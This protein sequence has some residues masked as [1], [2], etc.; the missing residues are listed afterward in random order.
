MFFTINEE[1]GEIGL[2]SSF[3]ERDVDGEGQDA[4]KK[5]KATLQ[6]YDACYAVYDCHYETE[7]TEKDEL[8]F[9]MW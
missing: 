7:D 9:I 8:I 4:Y 3:R 1:I 5:L 2:D 6:Q